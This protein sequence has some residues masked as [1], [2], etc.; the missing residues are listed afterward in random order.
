MLK[1]MYSNKN[2]FLGW[3]FKHSYYQRNWMFN[4]NFH[5]TLHFRLSKECPSNSRK[6]LM[7]TGLLLKYHS[8]WHCPTLNERNVHLGFSCLPDHILMLPSACL[9]LPSFNLSPLHLTIELSFPPF[10]LATGPDL[11]LSQGD[12]HW[13]PL[14]LSLSSFIP[15]STA[16][17]APSDG[18]RLPQACMHTHTAPDSP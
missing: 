10:C 4:V 12:S 14:P 16:P 9:P 15:P 17:Q 18:P 7:L 13:P 11:H 2:Q 6:M 8:I 1:K 3:V 5:P